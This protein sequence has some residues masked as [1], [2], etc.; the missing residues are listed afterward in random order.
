MTQSHLGTATAPA[1]VEPEVKYVRPIRPVKTALC[2][3]T[4]DAVAVLLSLLLAA[5]LRDYLKH[6]HSKPILGSIPVSLTL[7]LCSLM[8]AGLYPGV[9]I[10]PVEEIRKTI[11]SI[12]L[13]F[14]SLWS[15]TL[16]LHDLSNSRLVC[17]FAYALAIVAVPSCRSLTRRLLSK[18][19]WWGSQVAILGSGEVGR[20]VLQKLQEN[21]AI[22]MKPIAVLDD[23]DDALASLDGSLATGPLDRCLEITREHRISYGIVCMPNLSRGEL[24]NLLEDYGKCFSHLMVIPDLIGITSL[25][26]SA[27]EVG[28][29]IG[30]EL[31]QQ[32]LRP[33]AQLIKRALDLS[34]TT[35]AIPIALPLLLLAMALIKLEDAGPMFYADE[36]VGR[37]GKG[38]KAW[39]LRTMV[40]NGEDTLARYLEANP[41]E[42]ES[43]KICQKLRHDPRITR[44]GRLLRKTSIDELP[45]LWNV[46][47][48]EMS[49][50]GPRPMLRKQIHLYGRSFSLYIRV[51]PGITGLWQVSGRNHLTFA[52]RASLDSYLIRNWSPWL[53]LY[54]LFRTIRVVL[55]ARGAY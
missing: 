50:V 41:Q 29:I 23:D 51:R 54:I 47:I 42:K 2:L 7:V 6:S 16:F 9:G 39:K 27:R 28:G 5:L 48:G 17:A 13:A 25:G 20:L 31:T 32:L 55:T 22:G 52:D 43:W 44:V 38:F 30:L 26:I 21:P 45:Q 12:T 53:D 33:S 3:L 18:K 40:T 46:L 11:S 4:S 1:R 15:A 34:L 8:A 14:L 35:A 24:M 10:N 19:P 49:L 36:R 37:R